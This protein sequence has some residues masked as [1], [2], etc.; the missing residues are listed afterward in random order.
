MLQRRGL[1]ELTVEHGEYH[2][3]KERKMTMDS[4]VKG[5]EEG[6]HNKMNKYLNAVDSKKMS[7]E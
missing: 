5:S 4:H 2:R 1:V 3:E 7:D 6:S